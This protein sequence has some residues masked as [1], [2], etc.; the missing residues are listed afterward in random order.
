MESL[1]GERDVE[2]IW[3]GLQFRLLYTPWDSAD[4]PRLELGRSKL[5]HACLRIR[6]CF[7]TR[8]STTMSDTEDAM[9][10]VDENIP[11]PFVAKGKGKADEETLYMDDTLPW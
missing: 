5:N 11:S 8:E 9:M 2:E 4:K 6:L 10:D 1:T 3:P 7:T